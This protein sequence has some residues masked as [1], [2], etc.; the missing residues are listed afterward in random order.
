MSRTTPSAS[1]C[2]TT[3]EAKTHLSRLL[4]RVC[5]G[6]QLVILRGTRPIARLVPFDAERSTSP[7]RPPVGTVTSAPV[8]WDDDAFAPLDDTALGNWGL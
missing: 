1:H 5:A 8:Q 4:T 3:H 7:N 2:V 6:E